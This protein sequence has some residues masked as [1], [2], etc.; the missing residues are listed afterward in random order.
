MLETQFRMHT[1]RNV[2]VYISFTSNPIIEDCSEIRFSGYP[3]SLRSQS[4]GNQVLNFCYL[5]RCLTLTLE[6]AYG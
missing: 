2:D 3:H 6:F 1:S 5:I 4:G